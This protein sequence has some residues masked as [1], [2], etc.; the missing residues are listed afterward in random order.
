MN[1]RLE[2]FFVD[3]GLL[4]FTRFHFL[5][6]FR[7]LIQLKGH[8]CQFLSLPIIYIH[9]YTLA[10]VT[11]TLTNDNYLAPESRSV[12]SQFRG[13]FISI[14]TK[15]N[16]ERIEGIIEEL[17]IANGRLLIF[18]GELFHF[19]RLFGSFNGNRSCL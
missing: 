19:D 12:M 11:T 6:L 17:D 4:L 5:L 15:K 16:E 7:V 13:E 3:V 8:T 9:S 2:K 10:K 14:V 1:L 18:N